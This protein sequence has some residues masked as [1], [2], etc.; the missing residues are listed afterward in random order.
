[1]AAALDGKFRGLDG[2]EQSQIVEIFMKLPVFGER[3][4][5]GW[6]AALGGNAVPRWQVQQPGMAMR[7][8][9]SS[10]ASSLSPCV[11]RSK[12]LRLALVTAQCKG[13][14]PGRLW[15]GGPL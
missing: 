4:G 2:A 15:R 9:S 13:L 8:T 5:L 7:R 1:M 6:H 14:P 3:D 12:P 11:Q 10:Q